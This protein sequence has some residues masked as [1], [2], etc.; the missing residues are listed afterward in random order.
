MPG[1]IY[2]LPLFFT[3][4]YYSYWNNIEYKDSLSSEGSLYEVER[5]LC[6]GRFRVKIT[7][8][9]FGHARSL[10]EIYSPLVSAR[11][12]THLLWS[13]PNLLNLGRLLF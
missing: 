8:Q 2:H 1:S 11:T 4:K 6:V 7:E 3:Y 12:D 9:I 10:E 13:L 5:L